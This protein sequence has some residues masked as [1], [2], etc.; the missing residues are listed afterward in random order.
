MT[1][2][3]DQVPPSQPYPYIV[4]GE[5]TETEFST[6]ARGG[7]RASL[8]LEVRSQAPESTELLNVYDRVREVLHDQ[9][10]AVAGYTVLLGT[11]TLLKTTL[12]TDGVTR[13]GESRFDVVVQEEVLEQEMNIE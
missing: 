9:P 12:D 6:F 2:V 1:G 8:A 5:K 10:L 13:R 11:L 7:S 3:F 4:L